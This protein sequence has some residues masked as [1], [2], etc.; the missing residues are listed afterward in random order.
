[1]IRFADPYFEN[2][3]EG[4]FRSSPEGQFLSVNLALA[5]LFG[6][7]SPEKMLAE[8]ED[9]STQLY[10]DAGKR[11]KFK[12][13]LMEQGEIQDFVFVAYRRDGSQIWVSIGA[14]VVK[15]LHGNLLYYEGSCIDIT[16]RKQG[17]D[18]LKQQ[19]RE[20][21]FEIDHS[22]RLRQVAAISETDY[23]QQLLAEADDLRYSDD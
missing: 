22:Q 2:A 3:L 19:L 1:M 18:S 21:Q 4:I 15:D 8:V 9:I 20:L 17:E 13:L 10:V 6:Y 11:D 14:R 7:A 5:K 16:Q 12:R 23:F